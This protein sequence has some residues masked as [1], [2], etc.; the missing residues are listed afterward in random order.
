MALKLKIFQ[1]Q[2]GDAID[3]SFKDGE[4]ITRHVMVDSGTM[5]SYKLFQKPVFEK[6]PEN[7]SI[8]LWILTHL[9]NDHIM[10]ALACFREGAPGLRKKMIK[11]LWFNFFGEFK[12]PDPNGND[13]SMDKAIKL[14]DSLHKIECEKIDNNIHTGI[15]PFVFY[16]ATIT[17]LSPDQESYGQ[18]KEKW[19]EYEREFHRPA[20]P[21]NIANEEFP[22]DKLK[23]NELSK[24]DDRPEKNGD[25]VNKS[26]IAFLLEFG[27]ESILMLGDALPSTIIESLKKI[28]ADRGIPKLQVTYLKLAH[29]GSINNHNQEL[30]ELIECKNFIISTNGNSTNQNPNKET[31]A[32]ILDRK[33]CSQHYKLFFNYHPT[34]YDKL[35]SVDQNAETDYNF[36][37]IFPEAGQHYLQIP[38][39]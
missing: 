27:T 11:S 37:T 21:E 33:D 12:M 17:I 13:I 25:I 39:K 3:I 22:D 29:H 1:A 14:R 30:L 35:F 4:G 28:N 31:I 5:G 15:P 6:Y 23:I 26:S 2:K 16:G 10:G 19:E 20:T 34:R 38:T 32:K 18:L 8:D 36:S 7:E 9:D 24:R